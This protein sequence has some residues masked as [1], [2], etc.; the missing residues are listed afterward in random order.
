MA[1]VAQQGF[2][3]TSQETLQQADTLA[4][5]GWV[6]AWF[7]VIVLSLAA[8]VSTI[9]RGILN[10]IVDPVRHDLGVS[11]VQIGLLQGL[12]FGIFYAV[13]GIPLGLLA[14]TISRRRV[15]L[16]AVLIW[17]GATFLSGLANSFGEMFLC[18][19]L[20]GFA[21]AALAPCGMSMIT[22]MFPSSR[23][24]KPMSL[25]I[26]GSAISGG[27]SIFVTGS[28]LVAAPHGAFNFIPFVA[29][30][31]PWR[32]AFMICGMA[33]IAVV[34]LLA[35]M[36]EP[37][38]R[39]AILA[40]RLGLGFRQTFRYIG[41]HRAVFLPFYLGYGMFSLAYS[42]L[43]AWSPSVLMRVFGVSLSAAAAQLGSFKMV[44]SVIGTIA[45]GVVI[46]MVLR[47]YGIRGKLLL[48]AF[49]PA[50]AVPSALALW[51]PSPFTAALLLAEVSLVFPFF[52]TAVV[53]SI[54]SLVPADMKGV[55]ASLLLFTAT[56]VGLSGGPLLVAYVGEHLLGAPTAVGMAMPM[57]AVPAL[58][59][60]SA[61]LLTAQRA[62][63]R[64]IA[65]GKPIARVAQAAAV[66]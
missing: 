58:L 57:V 47:R 43:M 27:L 53:G 51:A 44:A 26:F 8:I 39:G 33:G 30:H 32:V 34:A 21:E 25:Y 52:G 19:L 17:S 50:T 22:D 13:A 31:A 46:D 55:A 3:A 29:G 4:Y 62:L 59:L 45:A 49:V 16:M 42:A 20:V 6:S 28:V 38:R 15:L 64:A 66:Q 11:D 24:S 65:A 35:L 63:R 7:G 36:R 14:D 18:R 5:P 1:T 41:D 23:R 9:D 61:L 60:S 54:P 12:A 37:A 56:I 2:S 40:P 48:L 10:L